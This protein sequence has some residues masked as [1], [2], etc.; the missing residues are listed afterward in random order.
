[1]SNVNY[2]IREYPLQQGALEIAYIE[3]FFNEFPERKTA[4][5][6]IQRLDGRE[7]QILMAEAVAARR[8]HDG[9]ARVLQGLARTARRGDRSE[10]GRSRRAASR[11]DR[12]RRTEDSLQLARRHAARL[13]RP[14][15]FPRAHR[16]TGSLGRRAGLRRGRSSRRRTATTTCA[17]RSTAC[18]STSS[19]WSRRPT[20]SSRRS[21][22]ASGSGPFVLDA[23]RSQRQVTRA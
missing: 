16:G 2:L 15:T 23:H 6:I 5:E 13:A 19:S 8:R 10:A 21:T 22:S 3:E 11:H 7:F 14:G 12:V 9:R 1:M 17:A 4:A 18:S 20:R